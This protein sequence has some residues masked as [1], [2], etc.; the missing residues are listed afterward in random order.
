MP[1]G[2]DDEVV[3]CDLVKDQVRVGR[4]VDAADGLIVRLY[5]DVRMRQQQIDNCLDAGVNSRGSLRRTP[6][7]VMQDGFEIGEGR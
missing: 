5:S 2:M 4:C 6:Y 3:A 1:H 7:D